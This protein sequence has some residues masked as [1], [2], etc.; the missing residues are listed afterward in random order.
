M[1]ANREVFLEFPEELGDPLE[2][3]IT[4][5]MSQ[6]VMDQFEIVQV[7]EEDGDLSREANRTKDAS[8]LMTCRW[9]VGIVDR[10]LPALQKGKYRP[11][12]FDPGE[13][14]QVGLIGD[15]GDAGRC[16]GLAV[17]LGIADKQGFMGGD[18]VVFE[19]PVQGIRMGFW[20]TDLGGRHHTA[21]KSGKVELQEHC[22]H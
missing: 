12:V 9:S 8:T 11:M 19:D 7:D 22:L 6:P 1:L 4:Y 13:A 16:G 3:V 15:E 5:R 21:E 17:D 10:P 20:V 2:K 14:R 18:P